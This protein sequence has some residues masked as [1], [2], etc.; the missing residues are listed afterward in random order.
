[1]RTVKHQDQITIRITQTEMDALVT[2]T[3]AHL[4]EIPDPTSPLGRL[5]AMATM[6]VAATIEEEQPHL[7]P[8][9][10]VYTLEPIV[11]ELTVEVLP[12]ELYVVC[13]DGKARACYTLWEGATADKFR[14]DSKVRK[15]PIAKF[16][17]N[18]YVSI[19]GPMPVQDTYEEDN[20]DAN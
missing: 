17:S 12:K 19:H 10:D 8:P 14:R 1:M 16:L 13:E 6:E 18:S 9:V 5:L 2:D 7:V 4:R 20:K 11:R 3:Y 15:S